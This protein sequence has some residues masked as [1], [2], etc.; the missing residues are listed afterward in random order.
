MI[1][2]PDKRVLDSKECCDDCI[3]KSLESIQ[4][5]RAILID[6]QFNLSH[7][8]DGSVYLLSNSWRKRSGNS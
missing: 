5:I 4:A 1:R 8:H 3:K 7:V 6:K 2:L